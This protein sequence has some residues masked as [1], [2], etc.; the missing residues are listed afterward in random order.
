M[1]DWLKEALEIESELIDLR[2]TLHRHPE[3]GN[4]EVFTS[5][6]LIS[7]LEK[8]GIEIHRMMETAA[9]GILRGAYPGATAA[10]RTDMDALPIVEETGLPFSSEHEGFMHA[11]GHDVHMAALIGA[12]R[13]LSKHRN[14]M[15]G[16]IVF[17]LQPA[18]ENAGGAERMIQNGALEG[19][20][21]V[22]G[23][24]CNPDLKAGTIGIKYGIFY[25]TSTRF[26]VTVH[27]KG[28]HGAEPENGIDPLYAACLM[29]ARLKGLTGVHNGLRDVVSVGML[30]A[31]KARN[32][33]PDEAYF[34]GILRTKGFTN[35]DMM[36]Q[37]IIDT[38]MQ[39][40]EETG[41][42]CDIE[43]L[44]GYPG[45]INHDN[46]TSIAEHSAREVLGDENV[47]VMEEGT[48]TS[49]DFGYFL[50]ERP[51]CFYHIGVESETGLHSPLFNPKESA[52]AKASAVHAAVLWKYLEENKEK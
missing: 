11:C 25:A 30:R 34:M 37:K 20:D 23:A 46:E 51:G 21:A 14:E 19:V 31:G 1:T 13:L 40:E 41:V 16:N 7:E 9:V 5:S 3:D 35:R 18:E 48:M 22:F 15:H 26:N 47:T 39:V 28:C 10:L 2:R 45:V 27:G 33:I 24:H 44:Y 43:V 4:E 42:Y 49:E 32:I 17:L 6:L 38:I 29:C 12:A 52:I 50:L 36:T 8:C